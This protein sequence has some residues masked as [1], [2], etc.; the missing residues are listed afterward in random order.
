MCPGALTGII[1]DFNGVL[2]WDNHLHEYAWTQVSTSHRG[3][4]FSAEEIEFH[5]H[6]RNNRH[7]LEYLMGR[8]LPENELVDLIDRKE[9]IYRRLCLSQPA[10][11]HLSPGA[12]CLLDALVEQNIPRTIATAAGRGNLDFYLEHL[13]LDRW[14]DPNL[15]VYDD[16]TR[17]GKPAPDMYLQSAAN[18][19]LDPDVCVVVED[20]VSGIQAAQAAGIG[21]IFALGPASTHE[22]LRHLPGVS[23]TIETL[24]Q[25][26]WQDIGEG[27]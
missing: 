7:T 4:P 22:Q 13:K 14:F 24:D 15:I 21:C 17:P 6:G 11:F 27:C 5:V 2:L 8:V 20:S 9:A 26:Q 25:I 10:G 19:G 18:L 23:R 16:G 12:I 3:T 1:F